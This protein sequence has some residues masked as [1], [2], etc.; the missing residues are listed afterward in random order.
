MAY[1]K[2]IAQHLALPLE[3]LD[4]IELE[5]GSPRNFKDFEQGHQ[6]DVVLGRAFGCHE[7]CH[8]VEDI[9]EAQQSSNALVER[10][11]VGD[12][13]PSAGKFRQF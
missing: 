12:H 10:I 9:V 13:G 5:V 1:I 3:L 6:R 7:M 11:F 8:P 4:K 2:D